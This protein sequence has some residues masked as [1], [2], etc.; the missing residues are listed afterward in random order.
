MENETPKRPGR[1]RKHEGTRP[2]WKVRL[3]P[4]LGEQIVEAAKVE[5][6]SISEELE[7]R[8]LKGTEYQE[9]WH[10]MEFTVAEGAIEYANAIINRN[11]E[12]ALSK[13]GYSSLN[14]AGEQAWVKPGGNIQRV[15][16]AIELANSIQ[17]PTDGFIKTLAA[18]ISRNMRRTER[19]DE[20]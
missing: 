4:K 18:E 15:A 12:E 10:D 8:I 2:Q 5:G 7:H 11:I 19:G 6:R 9:R 14:I 13:Y 3:P 16:S 20:G 17:M 1:P